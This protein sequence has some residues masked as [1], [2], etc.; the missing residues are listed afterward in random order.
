MKKLLKSHHPI[1]HVKSFKYAFQGLAHVVVNEAN[2]RVQ[3]VIVAFFVCSGFYF[4]ISSLEWAVLILSLGLL[5]SAE[6]LNTVVEEFIDHLIKEH[7]EAARVIKD[8][9]AGY[10]LITALTSLFVFV[11]TVGAKMF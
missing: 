3:I 1:R 8:L 9:S 10:V 2:F 4:H 7:N 6:V 11:F 5:L